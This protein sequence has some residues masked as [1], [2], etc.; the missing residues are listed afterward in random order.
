M[1]GETYTIA[2]AA[3]D[4]A[5]ALLPNEVVPGV[6]WRWEV[7]G[8]AN[9]IS[10]EGILTTGTA[11]G[12]FTAKAILQGGG[13]EL[14]AQVPFEVS[15]GPLA[16]IMGLPELV[17]IPAGGTAS[18]SI[19]AAD[20][21]GNSIAGTTITW[22]MLNDAGDIDGASGDFVASTL[23]KDYGGSI[24][25]TATSG[26]VAVEKTM[27][28]SVG[29]GPLAQLVWA[30]KSVSLNGGM[31]QQFRAKAGDEFGNEVTG[32]NFVWQA[33]TGGTIDGSGLYTAGND[34]GAFTESV[35]LSISLD[36]VELSGT[37]SVE[38]VQQRISYF[39]NTR[40]FIGQPFDFTQH[41][42]IIPFPG[43][44]PQLVL[45]R[46]AT[47]T[48]LSWLP[49]GQEFLLGETGLHGGI[50]MYLRDGAKVTRII[51]NTLTE[52]ATSPVVSPDGTKIAF[53]VFQP[54]PASGNDIF[55]V[56]IDGTN[57][58]RVTN[59]P[60]IHE[61][62]TAWSPDGNWLAFGAAPPRSAD[63][64]LWK[65]SIDGA[66]RIQLTDV[67]ADHWGANWSP[68]GKRIVFTSDRG[69]RFAIYTMDT[70]GGSVAR[71]TSDTQYFDY[72]PHWSSDGARI[73]FESN[74]TGSMEVW[75]MDAD[76]ANLEQVTNSPKSNSSADWVPVQT[77]LD[78]SDADLE[79][80]KKLDPLIAQP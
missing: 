25:L 9:V 38:I 57:R 11:A 78:I 26:D 19:R 31:P 76:G 67:G 59:I 62:V 68:N 27:A 22:S 66:Q 75:V 53:T 20:E 24:H 39:S 33:T 43:G 79:L 77:G 63:D 36:G 32:A 45:A 7:D 46:E 60:G 69:G 74:R 13:Q 12:S 34:A 8:E 42:Y 50:D 52:Q 6:S 56:D 47:S 49:N 72:S 40:L 16:S 15:P 64:E 61:R 28:V 30:P 58:I 71:L 29:P 17:E 70:D 37:S 3:F 80:L 51:E 44:E 10:P 41:L 23:A 5:D 48:Y 18:W 21:H 14:V 65:V 35:E 2:V 73:V 4:G 54:S 55:I 1:I